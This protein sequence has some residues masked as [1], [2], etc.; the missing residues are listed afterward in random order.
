[1]RTN[2]NSER[3]SFHSRTLLNELAARKIPSSGE[4]KM[5]GKELSA[6]SGQRSAI[7]PASPLPGC[8][9]ELHSK[10]HEC[11]SRTRLVR[12]SAQ[13][14]PSRRDAAMPFRCNISVIFGFVR[15]RPLPQTTAGLVGLGFGGQGDTLKDERLARCCLRQ[16][17]LS[18]KSEITGDVAA[19]T[20]SPRLATRLRCADPS[21]SRVRET[22]FVWFPSATQHDNRER[23]RRLDR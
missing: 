18:Y 7:K 14:K 15:Q 5:R 17:S 10:P 19:K 13:S 11:V 22:H 2:E 6:L 12:R 8:H 23:R 1:M 9:A 20:A 21:T 4:L 16:R 3:R